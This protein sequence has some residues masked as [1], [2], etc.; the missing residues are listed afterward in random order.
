ML[1]Y[2]KEV[3][4]DQ[5]VMTASNGN[6]ALEILKETNTECVI[7]DYMMPGISGLELTQKIKELEL[8]TSVILLTAKVDNDS[9]LSA[10]RL[11]VD[12]Y[13]HKPFIEE[14]LLL[15][16]KSLVE[17]NRRRLS[18]SGK[19]ETINTKSFK[20][21]FIENLQAIIDRKISINEVK[22]TDLAEELNVS[23]S[24]LLRNVK[25][26]TG[27]T[28]KQFIKEAGLQRFKRNTYFFLFFTIQ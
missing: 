26:F 13:M 15:R 10:L 19:E 18:F 24:T 27:L 8:D 6:E 28:T 9:K 22:I 16:V 1:A 12:D 4:D 11:G 5:T 23:E 2:L 21:D 3:F 17:N 20:N 7:T 14:E 25:S